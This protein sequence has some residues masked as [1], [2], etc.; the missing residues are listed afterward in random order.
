M[1]ISLVQKL[2]EPTQVFQLPPAYE[3]EWNEI[4]SLDC[5]R[6]VPRGHSSR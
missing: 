1:L 3:D 5:I 4:A 2:D 6:L